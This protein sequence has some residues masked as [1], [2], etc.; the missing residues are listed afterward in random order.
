MYY[1]ALQRSLHL[2]LLLVLDMRRKPQ[3][4]FISQIHHELVHQPGTPT[5]EEG[6]GMKLIQRA[7]NIT[8]LPHH[9]KTFVMI[10]KYFTIG[11]IFLP[12]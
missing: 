8:F 12:F 2:C 9:L 7:P 5:Q 4:N 1:G 6:K 3:N 10:G 11:S